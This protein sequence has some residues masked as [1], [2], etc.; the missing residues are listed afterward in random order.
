MTDVFVLPTTTGFSK[1]AYQ[2]MLDTSETQTDERLF[3]EWALDR[4]KESFE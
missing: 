1:I 4:Y 3:I 2:V